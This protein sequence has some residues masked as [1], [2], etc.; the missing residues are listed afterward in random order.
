M[1]EIL[2][3]TI[4]LKEKTP[5]IPAENRAEL[6]KNPPPEASKREN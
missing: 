4:H 3:K 6:L 1:K 2:Q 5:P